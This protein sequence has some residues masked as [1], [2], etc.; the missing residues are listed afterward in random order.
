M[1]LFAESEK[2]G[3]FQFCTGFETICPPI[4]NRKNP[5]NW[6]GYFVFEPAYSFDKISL[7]WA[8]RFGNSFMVSSKLIIPTKGPG[9]FIKTCVKDS[10]FL[11]IG[12]NACLALEFGYDHSHSINN[13]SYPYISPNSR[14]DNH[15]KN[16][17]HFFPS[18]SDL[19]GLPTTDQ[20]AWETLEPG[21]FKIFS[22]I[23]Q[24]R[25][26]FFG[27]LAGTVFQSSRYSK[28]G[29]L[30]QASGFGMR[31][32]TP[33]GILCLDLSMKW[34]ENLRI[35]DSCSWRITLGQSF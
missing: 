21:P 5:Q 34:A 10:V 9:I 4:A 18:L 23:G 16:T 19:H 29:G 27:Q 12:N 24:V 6:T 22:I 8:N 35:K 17:N 15:S 1:S 28:E 7:S 33:F 2:V 13:Q 30:Q 26:R 32:M 3:N 14:F 31:Y 20:V 25:V 11:P